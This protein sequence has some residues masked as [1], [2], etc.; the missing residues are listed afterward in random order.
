M[1]PENLRCHFCKIACCWPLKQVSG[2]DCLR[3]WPIALSLASARSIAHWMRAL[4]T[5]LADMAT[6][7]ETSRGRRVERC[8]LKQQKH[9]L[10]QSDTKA[11]ASKERFARP[12]TTL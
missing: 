1:A 7:N 8:I 4:S 3:P 2:G 9:Y 12:A 5:A 6:P 11:E 10:R